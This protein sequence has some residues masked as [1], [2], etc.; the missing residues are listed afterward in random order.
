[1]IVFH[2]LAFLEL[3]L[4]KMK[5]YGL[6]SDSLLLLR[7]CLT[8][9]FQ[10]VKIGDTFSDWRR[11]NRSIPQGFVLGPLLFNIL[12]NDLLYIIRSSEINTYADD[13]QFFTSDQ[14]PVTIQLSMQANLQS[15]SEWLQSNGMGR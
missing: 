12:K 10:R 3:L 14:D 15:V 9:C 8:D 4:A 13:T 6:S 7:S 11:I 1:M 5:S 2:I